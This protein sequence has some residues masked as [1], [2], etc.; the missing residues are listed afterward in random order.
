MRRVLG[1]L[2]CL[3]I[4][5][6]FASGQVTVH[7][8]GDVMPGSVYPSLKAGATAVPA[9]LFEAI[10][11]A[12]TGSDLLFANFEGAATSN[13]GDTKPCTSRPGTCYRFL[14]PPEA[15]PV[16]DAAGFHVLNIAG[17]HTMDAGP[18]SV[19][20]TVRLLE[21]NSKVCVAGVPARPTCSLTS[22]SGIRIHLTGFAPHTGALRAD[23]QTVEETVRGLKKPGEIVVVS[24]HIGAEGA[25]AQ[26]VTRDIEYFLGDNRGN[27]YDLAH[28]AIDAGAD[29]VLGHGPH[30]L[31]ALE[32]YRGR[33]IVYSMGNFST[34]GTVSAAPPMRYGAVFQIRLDD[35][36][37]FRSC[38]IVS[39]EQNKA[40]AEYQAGITPTPD[41]DRNAFRLVRSFTAQDFPG[42]PLRFSEPDLVEAAEAND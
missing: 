25:A 8:V 31:R 10:Q 2:L 40:S 38:R 35:D 1:S 17:N 12:L 22:A 30:V 14:I 24:F 23:R 5:Q 36:G 16:F 11:S 21:A 33:L 34:F 32:N 42:T 15:G 37:S 39:T 26:H 20:R 4:A 28:A 13:P 18:Q 6:A 7:A 27:V 19:E 3:A 29:L 41:P 9:R